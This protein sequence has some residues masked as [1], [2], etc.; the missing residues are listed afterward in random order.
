MKKL[1]TLQGTKESGKTR[2]LNM[3][4]DLLSGRELPETDTE[5][6]DTRILVEYK[7]KKIA[8]AT[9]G[10]GLA[11]VNQNIEFFNLHPETDVYISATWSY[12][13]TVKAMAEFAKVNNY[14]YNVVNKTKDMENAHCV[15][16]RDAKKVF[17]LI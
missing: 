8:I 15:N 14:S 10:D 4:I 16:I 12:G 17:N 1:I 13:A 11:I 7:G 5:R 6:E 3:V 2:T 9:Y